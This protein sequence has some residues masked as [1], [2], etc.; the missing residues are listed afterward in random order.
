VTISS[1][2]I[3][4]LGYSISGATF[5][6]TLR[7]NQSTSLTIQFDPSIAGAA[8]GQLTLVSNSSTGTSTAIAL[9]GTGVAVLTALSCT[10]S[11]MSGS[12][13]DAC[14][15]ALNAA[16]GSGGI[17]VG[18]S[19]NN[20]AVTVPTSIT[21]AA[22]SAS[23]SFSATVS[24]VT[25]AQAVTLSA[26]AGT[27]SK[28]FALQLNAAVA[29]LGINATSIAFGSVNLNTPATQ[30]IT[31]TSTGVLPV[32][33]SLV[34]VSGTGFSVSGATFPLSLNQSQT[35]TLSVV[36]DPTISGAA[37]GQLTIVS[38][39]LTNPTDV[40][41]LSG[42]GQTG[43]YEV[44]L[45]WNA[46]ASST[47]AVAGYNI[48]RSP[49]GSSTYQLLGTVSSPQPFVASQQLSYTDT[50]SLIDGQAYDYIVESVDGSGNESTPSNMA[51]VTIP[52]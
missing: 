51:A 21:I 18:L 41:N 34:T 36:F 5:P 42:T 4:G 17:T 40:V 27:I 47:D 15:V 50:S 16:A 6:L 33:V 26:N 23:A 37:T 13:T 49:S 52:N 24:S 43:T 31:L 29:T 14:T 11:S 22:G 12:G 20:S 7:K 28:T 38:T 39:S 45:T 25:T 2:T 44:N 35:V 9:N 30:T 1:A 46:P 10:D 8:T 32:T 19:S 48:Y 3:S